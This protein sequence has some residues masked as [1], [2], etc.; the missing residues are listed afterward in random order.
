MLEYENIDG[1]RFRPHQGIIL[2][3]RKGAFKMKATKQN[4]GFRPHQGIILFN[5]LANKA[6]SILFCSCFRPH[7]GIILF[8]PVF[9]T[10]DIY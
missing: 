3:N 10:T 4:T 8:N 2:F 1:V 7:Q 5:F 9:E 6:I